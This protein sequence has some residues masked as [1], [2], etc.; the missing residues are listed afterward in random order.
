MPQNKK[1]LAYSAILIAI[2]VICA[3]AF[4]T[5]KLPSAVTAF[6]ENI[7]SEK[8]VK[9]LLKPYSVMSNTFQFA[10][11][12]NWYTHEVSFAGGEILYHLNFMSQDKRI[13]GFVQAWQLSKPLKEFVEGSK[14]AA[15]GSVDFKDFIIREI[16][17]NN[18]RGYLLDYSR[19]NSEGEYNRSYEAFVE[20][21]S[22][23]VYRM[24]FF[25]PEKEWRSYYKALFDRII[26]TMN[27]K[28]L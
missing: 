12:D 5:G 9:Q 3:A 7:Q 20:G 24:S 4:I 15:T 18:R 26:R 8:A 10:L 28:K 11:P 1:K 25:V 17:I 22:G 6:K 16:M 19:A 13:H 2:L 27:I 23:K 14:A 21:Y